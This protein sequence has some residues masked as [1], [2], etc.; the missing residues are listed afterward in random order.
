MYRH[1]L[2]SGGEVAKENDS[3]FKIISMKRGRGFQV[4]SQVIDNLD[5]NHRAEF[6]MGYNYVCCSERVW[7]S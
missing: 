4:I 7:L 1:T 6:N 5:L 3:R 2:F